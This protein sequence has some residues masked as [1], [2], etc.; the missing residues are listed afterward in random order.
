MLATLDRYPTLVATRLYDRFVERGYTGSIRT[1]WRFVLLNRPAPTHEVYLRI[2]T[3]AG[4]QSQI[5]WVHVGKLRVSGGARPLYCFVL[6]LRYSRAIWAELV[7]EQTTA[8]LLRSLVRAAQYF[9]GVTHQWLFDNPKSIVAA[10]DG[11]AIRFQTELIELASQLHV[12]LRACRVPSL[13]GAAGGWRKPA[14]AFRRSR[15][16]GLRS[17]IQKRCSAG[18]RT[19]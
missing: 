2:E 15:T 3:L 11:S 1:P 4:E 18:C 14:G 16:R 10:R 19:R 13:S 8:S 5:D 6:V 9:G 7:L 17:R 12:A